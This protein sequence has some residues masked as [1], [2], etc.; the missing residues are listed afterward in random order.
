[1][2]GNGA[3]RVAWRLKAVPR[4]RHLSSLPC[5]DVT[6]PSGLEVLHYD[7]CLS[8]AFSSPAVSRIQHSIWLPVQSRLSTM[9]RFSHCSYHETVPRENGVICIFIELLMPLSLNLVTV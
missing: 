2:F 5:V 7:P 4:S 6:A 3:G 1:M 8:F 9:G